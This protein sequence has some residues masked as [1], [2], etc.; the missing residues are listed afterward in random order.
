MKKVGHF[1]TLDPLATGLL[2]IAVGKATRLF[3]FFQ[4]LDKTYRGCLRFGFATDTY[5]SEGMPITAESKDYPTRT[6]IQNAMSAF[7][8][9]IDQIPPAYSAKKHKGKRL[10]TLARE[11]RKI[12]IKPSK[13]VIYSFDL[14]GYKPPFLDFE[15]RCS[16]GTYIRSIAHDLG[17]RLGCG[18]H[19]TK[20]ERTEMGRFKS[21]RSHTL[22]KLEKLTGE[23]KT[24][25]FLLPLEGI[26]DEFPKI[27]LDEN[28]RT[29]AKNGNMISAAH[30]Q[31]IIHQ[32]NPD[33]DF[34]TFGDI[35]RLFGPDG[36]LI[37]FA[38]KHPKKPGLHPYLVIDTEVPDE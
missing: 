37:A 9:E 27:V 36:K 18:A 8:G 13:V 38:K 28:G 33:T 21:E 7:K 32:D 31:T 20:L 12:D 11:N 22:K 30:I 17:Q 6:D 23:R 15:V 34:K 2:M 24:E 19:L 26:L 29:L 14:L 4:K 5:D 1:G 3:P 25:K 10:Y 16:S 35:Y